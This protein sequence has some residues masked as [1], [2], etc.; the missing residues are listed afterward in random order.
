MIRTS[1]SDAPD[2]WEWA[3]ARFEDADRRN[4]PGL[5]K[6]VFTGSSSIALWDTLAEDMAP[7]DVLN[8]GFGGS[9]IH[10]VVHYA[11]RVVIPYRPRA[12]VLF[13][14]TND[15]A[16]PRPKSPHH[17]YDW[18]VTFVETVGAA[19]A[20]TPI[21]FV[22]ITPAPSRRRYWP[23]FEEANDL[24]R[25]RT[26]TGDHLHYIDLVPSLLAADGQPRRDL[27][28]TD[29]LHPN[30]R[31]SQVWAGVIRPVLMADLGLRGG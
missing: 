27:F 11:D 5:G 19:L 3:I 8:R 29:R 30:Q 20:Q 12:V 2:S 16:G 18:Y 26:L 14:G 13:A 6:I 31:G 21:Y 7:L 1:M 24:I 22:S 15:I 9:R 4:P 10:Q 28:R 23:A 17:V 25:A